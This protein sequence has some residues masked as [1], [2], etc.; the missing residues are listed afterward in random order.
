MA[1]TVRSSGLWN[2][3]T[4]SAIPTRNERLICWLQVV[5]V[6]R[7]ERLP[8]LTKL[9]MSAEEPVKGDGRIRWA[10][11]RWR[12]CSSWSATG[13]GRH[14]GP[15]VGRRRKSEGTVKRLHSSDRWNTGRRHGGDGG[16]LWCGSS[17]R[18]ATERTS[19]LSYTHIG[20]VVSINQSINQF[21]RWPK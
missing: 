18:S 15:L 13:L 6:C 8:D 14:K 16:R 7:G 9:N 1:I 17:K 21:L 11:A 10:G 3:L 4:H 20:T 2:S 19:H 12:W 5:W